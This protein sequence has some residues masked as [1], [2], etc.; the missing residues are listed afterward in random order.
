M[1]QMDQHAFLLG[2]K[3]ESEGNL[4]FHNLWAKL[5][6]GNASFQNI[7]EIEILL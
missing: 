3:W 5:I 4:Q 2:R 1:F 6:Y 7:F